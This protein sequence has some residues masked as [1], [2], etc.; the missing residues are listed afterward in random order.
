MEMK[1]FTSINK[2]K[3]IWFFLYFSRKYEAHKLVFFLKE[4][5]LLGRGYSISSQKKIF[6]DFTKTQKLNYVSTFI[7]DNEEI[8]VLD[9]SSNRE[10]DS[11]KLANSDS[12][13]TRKP[14]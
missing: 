9:L 12:K 3:I 2:R 1:I 10:S 4:T 5:N 11:Q 6:R 13:K 7:Y 14:H 8:K